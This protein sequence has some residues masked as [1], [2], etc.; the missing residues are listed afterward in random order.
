[1]TRKKVEKL[2]AKRT[3][4][5]N[6]LER[7]KEA[8]RIVHFVQGNLELTEW[9]INTIE[10]LPDNIQGVP[11]DLETHY[12]HEYNYLLTVL[13]SLP[14]YNQEAMSST[15]SVAT[16][17][18]NT[19]YRFVAQLGES[20]EPKAKAY[21]DKYT[22]LYQ[23]IQITQERP[24]AVRELLE[25]VKDNQILQRFDRAANAYLFVKSGTGARTAA[26]V[27]MRTLL[28]GLQGV[29]FEKARKIPKENM[30]WIEMAKRLSKGERDGIEQQNLMEPNENRISLISR[31]SSVLKDRDKQSIINLDN[32]WSQ[33][34]DHIFVVLGLI[35]LP[36]DSEKDGWGVASI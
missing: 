5:Q 18:S 11:K 33:L 22:K 26:A 20:E 28:D 21:S 9:E 6:W 1:M 12:E 15:L 16:S 34:L 27:E 19:L 29:L 32:L 24:K 17:G 7:N 4:L 35:K 3:H 36:E 14:K 2:E 25:K 13:P 8:Q 23:G 30:T 31:L 10:N